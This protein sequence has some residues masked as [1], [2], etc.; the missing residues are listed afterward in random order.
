MV[1]F[2]IHLPLERCP[3][4]GVKSPLL[5]N[6]SGGKTA[7]YDGNNERFWAVFQC[8]Q[9]GGMVLGES[10]KRPKD[11]TQEIFPSL[12]TVH[13]SIPE[14]ARHYLGEAYEALH[15]PSGCIMLCASAVDA[16]L[17]NKQYT[18]GSLYSRIDKA[19]EDGVITSDM[20]AWAHKVR[21]EANE[22]RHADEES[23]LPSPEEAQD[24]LDFASAFAEY[25]FVLPSKIQKGLE[26]PPPADD[27]NK[28]DLADSEER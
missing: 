12:P 3:R 7:A 21:L 24:C 18:A 4:C 17:K 2:K 25:L 16:M 14:R 19:A 10:P 26:D 22:E 8:S 28:D 15:T 20:S 5:S 23:K 1:N 13:H 9:C 6:V 11:Y 27:E